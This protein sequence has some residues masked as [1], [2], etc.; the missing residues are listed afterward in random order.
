MSPEAS[1]TQMKPSPFGMQRSSPGSPEAADRRSTEAEVEHAV[2]DDG[3]R[4]AVVADR[5]VGGAFAQGDADA[6]VHV[7]VDVPAHRAGFWQSSMPL[8]P[9]P[10]AG[11]HVAGDLGAGDIGTHLVAFQAPPPPSAQ[12]VHFSPGHS[13]A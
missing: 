2:V 12:A 1:R 13:P 6:H 5:G 3:A 10:S 9:L 4:E 11:A 7:L 8:T